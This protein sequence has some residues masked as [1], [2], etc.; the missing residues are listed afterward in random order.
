MRRLTETGVLLQMGMLAN[1]KWKA[2]LSC[3]LVNA[4]KSGNNFLGRPWS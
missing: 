1:E 3:L 2:Q 4:A